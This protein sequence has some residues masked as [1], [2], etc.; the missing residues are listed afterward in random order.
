MAE[1]RNRVLRGFMEMIAK[2][3]V[4]IHSLGISARGNVNADRTC[5]I[6]LMDVHL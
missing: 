1:R 4:R 3:I 6:T 2:S 5:V